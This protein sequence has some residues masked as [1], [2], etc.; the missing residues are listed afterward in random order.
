VAVARRV[1]TAADEAW[2]ILGAPLGLPPA[3]S[4]PV[5]VRLAPASEWT[6]AVP[7]LAVVEA[8]GVVTVQIG[9][10]ESLPDAAIQRALT[11]GLLLRL[12]VWRHGYDERFSLPLWLEHG[13]VGWWRTRADAAQLD[14]LKQ[15][16][17]RAAPPGIAELLTWRRG[18]REPEARTLGAVW[19]YEFL[20]SDGSRAGE[21]PSFLTRLLRGDE[22]LA[23][24]V[25]AYPGRFSNSMERELWWVTGWH[26]LRTARALPTL[27]A[28]E[29][30]GQLE[31][32]SR[33][34]VVVE[35]R[36]TSPPLDFII[37]YSKEPFVAEELARRAHVL[38][39]LLPALHPFYRNAGM[40]LAEILGGTELSATKRAEAGRAFERDWA[41]ARELEDNVKAALDAWDNLS[42]DT[43]GRAVF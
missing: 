9:G 32:L 10:A 4:S 34:V 6:R 14:A 42:G 7:F 17:A 41:A 37:T 2:R 31:I 24:L 39:G 27:E 35:G 19:L 12:A 25:A 13:C 43:K 16:T 15:A 22:P 5:F 40:S 8:G 18:E 20:R 28:A 33:F 30:R 11:R 21:W 29:S 36:E 1:I 23:A 26:N 38:N 3:F